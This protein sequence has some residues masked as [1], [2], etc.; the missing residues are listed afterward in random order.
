MALGSC[1]PAFSAS[2]V[3]TILHHACLSLPCL[4]NAYR[5]MRRMSSL[6]TSTLDHA[7][8]M[9]LSMHSVSV[10]PSSEARALVMHL[11]LTRQWS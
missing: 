6:P 8:M 3:F 2:I 7:Q 1:F 4:F 9:V 10:L 11:S 5:P